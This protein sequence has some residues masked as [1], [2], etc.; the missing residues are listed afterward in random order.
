MELTTDDK[1]RLTEIFE[2]P[3]PEQMAARIFDYYHDADRADRTSRSQMYLHMGML[4][5]AVMRALDGGRPA[6]LFRR[7]EEPPA[8][9][10]VREDPQ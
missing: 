9:T 3:D 10:A 5:G 6:R 7:R 1:K 8:D 2:A 4:A